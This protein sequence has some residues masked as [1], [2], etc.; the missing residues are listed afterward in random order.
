M[1]LKELVRIPGTLNTIKTQSPQPQK[2]GLAFYGALALVG[3]LVF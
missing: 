1:I 2:M 3:V